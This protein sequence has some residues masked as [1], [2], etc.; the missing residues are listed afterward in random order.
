MYACHGHIRLMQLGFKS[1]EDFGRVLIATNNM[2]GTAS[3]CNELGLESG[4]SAHLVI[5]SS[6][7]VPKVVFSTPIYFTCAFEETG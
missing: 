4:F 1:S 2:L 3:N 6:F 7:N 5:V